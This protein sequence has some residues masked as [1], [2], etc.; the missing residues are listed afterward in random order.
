MSD[1]RAPPVPGK[2]RVTRKKAVKL[3]SSC[4]AEKWW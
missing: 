3:A 1:R 4:D 2:R